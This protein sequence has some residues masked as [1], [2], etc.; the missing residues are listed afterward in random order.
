MKNYRYGR[1]FFGAEGLFRLW[2]VIL[3]KANIVSF[4]HRLGIFM[5][6][7]DPMKE[8]EKAMLITK[9]DGLIRSALAKCKVFSHQAEYEDL[10]QELRIELL[11]LMEDALDVRDF[12]RNYNRSY[13][14]S[15]FVWRCTDRQRRQW[16]REK[17]EAG[18]GL[19]LKSY[20][21]IGVVPTVFAEDITLADEF[22]RISDGLSQKE[23]VYLAQLIQDSTHSYLSP[24][25]RYYYRKRLRE[26]FQGILG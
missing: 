1:H 7:D 9:Y 21:R 2:R 16:L 5:K 24:Q 12:Q 8:Y 11:L 26:S 22:Q 3:E 25:L 13:L 18:I 10:K 23:R 14:F 15:R 6:D 4:S 20:E 19:D 17:R